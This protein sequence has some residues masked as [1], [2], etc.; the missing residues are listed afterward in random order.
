[1]DVDQSGHR[2]ADA[3]KGAPRRWLRGEGTV[4]RMPGTGRHRE[5]DCLL[6]SERRDR[7]D[8][9]KPRNDEGESLRSKWLQ[10][11]LSA[12]CGCDLCTAVHSQES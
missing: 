2:R 9:M 1:M 8:G 4:E 5:G 12:Q 6:L 7:Q 3:K 11:E 10:T